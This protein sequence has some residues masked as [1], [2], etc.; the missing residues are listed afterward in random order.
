MKIWC[1]D[2]NVLHNVSNMHE[3]RNDLKDRK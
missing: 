1:Y 3:Y 2:V